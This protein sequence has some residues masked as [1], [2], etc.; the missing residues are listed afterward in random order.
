MIVGPVVVL[1]IEEGSAR[2]SLRGGDTG[3]LGVELELNGDGD[4]EG[5]RMRFDIVAAGVGWRGFGVDEELARCAEARS[6]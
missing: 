5:E 1:E 2:D 6:T 4:R 3:A